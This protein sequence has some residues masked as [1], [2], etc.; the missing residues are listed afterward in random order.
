[1]IPDDAKTP[2]RWHKAARWV[3]LIIIGYFVVRMLQ[4]QPS[5]VEVDYHF[6]AAASGLTVATMRYLRGGEEARR[7]RFDYSLQGVGDPQRHQVKLQDGQY[8]VEI[9]LQYEEQVPA[10]LR[11]SKSTLENGGMALRLTRLLPVEGSGKIAIYL[12][13]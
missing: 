3:V 9:L 4:A 7:V 8:T 2:T 10:G 12:A 6:G 1:M 11:G 13:R 5:T